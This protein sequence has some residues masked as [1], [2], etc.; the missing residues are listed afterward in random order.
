MRPSVAP[1]RTSPSP[2]EAFTRTCGFWRARL[3]AD[4]DFEAFD[5]LHY[6][7]EN[8][9]L[10]LISSLESKRGT[11]Q[12]QDSLPPL[13]KNPATHSSIPLSV[14]HQSGNPPIPLGEMVGAVRFELTTF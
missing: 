8:K 5:T 9:L 4:N 11:N 7:V 10:L 12:W 6:E 2:G 1:S 3:F 14:P 13:S